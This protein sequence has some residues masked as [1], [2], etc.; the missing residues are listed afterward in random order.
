VVYVINDD[1]YEEPPPSMWVKRKPTK[2]FSRLEDITTAEGEREEEEGKRGDQR[3]Y[4]NKIVPIVDNDGG[5]YDY[6]YEDED[7]EGGNQSDVPI[8]IPL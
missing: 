2:D 5:D 4:H 8:Q 1:D 7:D 6:D 3:R